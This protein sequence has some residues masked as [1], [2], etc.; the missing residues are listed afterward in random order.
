VLR[1]VTFG[2]LGFGVVFDIF[3]ISTCDCRDI[4]GK[5]VLLWD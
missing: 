4:E 5:P 1:L 2:I 3:M